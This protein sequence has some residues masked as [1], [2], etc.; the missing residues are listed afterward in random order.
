VTVKIAGE[1]QENRTGDFGGFYQPLRL[2][3]HGGKLLC[4]VQVQW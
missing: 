4:S 1:T 3:R 2:S